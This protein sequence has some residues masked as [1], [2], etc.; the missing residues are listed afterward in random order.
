MEIQRKNLCDNHLVHSL[1]IKSNNKSIKQNSEVLKV[2][3]QVFIE[4]I[5][6]GS[7]AIYAKLLQMPG[8]D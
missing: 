1:V 4:Q 2:I 7:Q 3:Y 8:V 6:K 5:S